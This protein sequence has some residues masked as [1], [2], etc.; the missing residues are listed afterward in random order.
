MTIESH[1]S[2]GKVLDIV[3]LMFYAYDVC[4]CPLAVVIPQVTPTLTLPLT[5][6]E[7]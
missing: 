3:L 2:T 1:G 6:T 7:L 5:L 4:D